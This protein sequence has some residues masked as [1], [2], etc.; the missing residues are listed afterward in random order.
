MD[1]LNVDLVILEYELIFTSVFF[2]L[3]ILEFPKCFARP[4]FGSGV[5]YITALYKVMLLCQQM[6]CLWSSHPNLTNT[7]AYFS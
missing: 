3:I 1:I 5:Y 4:M 7:G 6:M 2:L